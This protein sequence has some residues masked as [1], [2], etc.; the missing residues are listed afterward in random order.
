M[1]EKMSI[2]RKDDLCPS[3]VKMRDKTRML[4]IFVCVCTGFCACI[5][6]NPHNTPPLLT[7][8]NSEGVRL[9]KC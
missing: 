1:V 2:Q 7:L 8:T 4:F 9:W 5:S 3:T 6:R